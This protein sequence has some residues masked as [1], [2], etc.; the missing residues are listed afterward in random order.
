VLAVA[1]A[2]A[3]TADRTATPTNPATT[4]P[5]AEPGTYPT[6]NGELIVAP[7]LKIPNGNVPW[8]LDTVNN[9]QV[10]V[11]IHHTSLKT[12]DS[13]AEL[14]DTTQHTPL[15]SATPAFFVHSGDLTENTGD[16]GHGT[17]T[18]WALLPVVVE[19]S[20]RTVVRPAFADVNS[21]TVCAPPV[22]C[23]Q[24][25]SLPDGWL[26]ITPK[27]PLEPGE[28][29]LL[30]VQRATPES[31]NPLAYD[32]TVDVQQP[33]AK[34]TVSPGQNLDTNKKKGHHSVQ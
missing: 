2:F 18:G 17:P 16:S 12:T 23:T 22:I 15:H 21:A 8:A 5:A 26:R 28:Y 6:Q 27:S 4:A 19:G 31:N 14:E 24:A 30:P 34:D 3:Q 33:P 25:E 7:G 20:S 1:A 10:L 32:F 11:P 13:P 29:A 9:Q